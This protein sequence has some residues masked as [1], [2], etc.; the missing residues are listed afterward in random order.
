MRIYIVD[1]G[2]WLDGNLSKKNQRV[3]FKFLYV[4]INYTA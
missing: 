3:E 4:Y 2:V 1:L